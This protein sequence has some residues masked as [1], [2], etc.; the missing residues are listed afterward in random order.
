MLPRITMIKNFIFIFFLLIFGT[1]L[2]AGELK[3]TKSVF[4]P[5]LLASSEYCKNANDY[6]KCMRLMNG[7][8]LKR[9]STKEID[10]ISKTCNPTEAK[11]YGTDN[12]GLKTIPGYY[13]RDVPFRRSSV[14]FSKPAKL[15]VNGKYGRYIH[16]HNISRYYSKGYSGSLIT[17]PGLYNNSFPTITYSPGE[18]PSI[19]QLVTNYVYDCLEKNYAYFE[20]GKLVR[21][22][23]KSGKKKKWLSFSNIEP[24][25]LNGRA[26][27]ICA[28]SPD[29]I[30]SLD[31]SFF[32]KFENKPI[33][34]TTNKS[35]QSLNINCESQV[36]KNKPICN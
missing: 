28:K 1:S 23:N 36:W 35:K 34:K 25:S 22:K 3:K 27:K 26:V 2:K 19:K 31:E 30:L 12:L 21:Q 6:E 8:D 13:F 18:S 9:P 17:S 4:I 20:G 7:G 24:Q 11:I 29:Y 33:K 15:K 5:V 32:T 10:C 16:F 14:Y